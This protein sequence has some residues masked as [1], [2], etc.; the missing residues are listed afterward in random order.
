[1][2]F[3]RSI[4][5]R[6]I[7]RRQ[8]LVLCATSEQDSIMPCEPWCSEPCGQ[9]NGDIA[10]ECSDCSDKYSCRPGAR[11]F[12]MPVQTAWNIADGSRDCAVVNA[13]DL[14]P[15][16][17][18]RA[19]NARHLPTLIRGLVNH[20]VQQQAMRTLEWE[21]HG[22]RLMPNHA[23]CSQQL[24]YLGK[25]AILADELDESFVSVCA[26]AKTSLYGLP[27]WSYLWSPTGRES[28][29]G[30]AVLS[31][32]QDVGFHAHGPTLNAL[33]IGRRH[34]F[35]FEPWSNVDGYLTF[36]GGGWQ[37]LGLLRALSLNHSR[38][39]LA[40]DW[41]RFAYPGQGANTVHRAYECIQEAGDVMFVP[42]GFHH[43]L[44]SQ[45]EMRALF[46]IEDRTVWTA[47]AK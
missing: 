21:W 30:Q 15:S 29:P 13:S 47:G 38:T 14:T 9:L 4:E 43:A 41:L 45:G 24:A 26:W 40:D 12:P 18:A 16:S 39:N 1:M 25:N 35:M 34:W 44:I 46:F 2:C 5:P 11:D 8:S 23:L 17:L 42:D 19:L 6:S 3:L 28:P 7:E 36:H 37:A 31:S 20:A 32:N 33:L 22:R 10:G 27:L